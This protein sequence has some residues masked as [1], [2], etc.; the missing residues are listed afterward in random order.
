M[1]KKSNKKK[2]LIKKVEILDI[3]NKGKCI[4]R[5]DN[6]VIIIKGGVPGDICDVIIVKKKKK[7]WEGNI[8]K[9]HN[10]SKLR[11]EAEC[12]HF[13]VCG[14]CKWQNMKYKSQLFFKQKEVINNLEKIGNVKLASYNDI[15][16]SQ[17]KYYYRN[18]HQHL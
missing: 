11:T 1:K 13:N 10:Y 12:E 18:H 2:I 5:D 16:G 9:I 17:Q 15:L 14:G 6:R 8:E 4:A 7:Y 3:A